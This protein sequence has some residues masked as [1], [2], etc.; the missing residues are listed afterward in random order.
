MSESTMRDRAA[1]WQRVENA[2]AAV[3]I[4]VVLVAWGRPWW[5][6]L[7]TFLLFD[8]SALGYLAGRRAGAFTYNLVHNFA[9]AALAATVWGILEIVGHTPDW[10]ALVAAVWAF[11]VAV[12]RALGFGLKVG[13]FNDTHLGPI[14][15]SEGSPP[16]FSARRS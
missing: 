5:L 13:T 10:L 2:L 6:P 7:A 1:G 8:L 14:G 12:D 11:H 16:G 4:V 3:S 15:R 9:P